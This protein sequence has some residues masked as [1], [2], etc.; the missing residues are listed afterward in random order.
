M[1]EQMRR[2]LKQNR[3]QQGQI[4]I[5]VAMVAVSM[6]GMIGLAVDLGYA[7]AQKRSVQNA[8]DAAASTGTYIVTQWSTTNNAITAQADV[9]KIIKANNMGDAT[10][11][12]SCFYVDDTNTKLDSCSKTVP[13]T[14]TGVTV[15]VSET[16]KT[17][18]M[19]V[20]P[21]APKTVTTSASATAH[22]EIV[23]PD[24]SEGPFIVCGQSDSSDPSLSILKK[25]GNSYEINDAAVGHTF[26]VHGSQINDCGMPS[27]SFKGLADQDYNKGKSLNDWFNGDT[28]VKA[29]PVRGLVRGIQGCQDGA[30]D[31]FDC[32]MYVPV[33]TNNPA[34]QKQGNKRLFYVVAYAAFRVSSC[35]ANCHQAT[36]MGK[37]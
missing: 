30:T 36:L 27:S 3:K 28:G 23:T 16:H 20:F 4:I 10:Q 22:A 7:F 8:A 21:G 11:S 17:F 33:A 14:A 9:N 25:V 2:F 26:K 32:V 34:P 29:G 12:F 37:Y 31:S 1:I 15:T 5:F 19:R 24:G 18:F 6:V 13:E 35:G